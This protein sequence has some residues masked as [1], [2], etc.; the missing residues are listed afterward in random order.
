MR[1]RYRALVKEL[2][3]LRDDMVARE[4]GLAQWIDG[5]DASY[6]PSAR[7]LAHYLALRQSD[8]RPLQDGL[9]SVGLCSLGN[10]ESNVLAELDK[11]LATLH[12]LLDEP[13]PGHSRAAPTSLPTAP[14]LLELHTSAL[15]GPPPH[16]AVRIMVTL[17]TEAATDPDFVQQLVES[18]MD[19]ARIN[20][21]HDDAPT[22]RKMAA[23]VRRAA[24]QVGHS[25]RILMDLAGPKLRTGAIA[26]GPAVLKL[27]PRKD[28]YG[29][30]IANAIV[31]LRP[32]GST[33][34]LDGV[35]THMGVHAKWLQHL[36]PGDHLDFTD[37]SGSTRTLCVIQIG[38][39]GAVAECSQTTYLTPH[40]R[41]KRRRRG[42]GRRTTPLADMP[43][44]EA[45][46]GLVR[47]SSLRLVREQARKNTN[48]SPS[49][50]SVT[51]TLPQ[52]FEQVRVGERIWF[53][54]GRIGGV[55]RRIAP[56]YLEVD[57]TQARDGGEKLYGD[58]GINLPD[59]QLNLPALTDKD[60]E[61]LGVVAQLADLVGLSFVQRPEDIECL[62]KHLIGLERANMGILLKIETRRG[63]ERLPELLLSAMKSASAGIMIARGDLAVECGFERLAEVQEEILWAAEAAH[64]PVIWATQVLD[65]LAKTGRP[66]RAEITDAAMGERAECVMLNKGPYIR[67]AMFTLNDILIRMQPHQTKR[68][69]RLRA[70][71]AWMTTP[72]PSRSM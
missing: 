17:P 69:P 66:T 64:M 1:I 15:L 25:V 55:I 18:G 2:S 48:G 12:R 34:P 38:S 24:I 3:T 35:S 54:D 9:D 70:L 52:V 21:A 19:I 51:C 46:I 57:I 62:H 30:V 22:W 63:F 61:D 50:A 26:A 72:A 36:R 16:R 4:A 49:V 71:H 11:V 33:T 28:A 29:I 42:P 44:I 45:V 31:G 41:V 20:C 56:Q 14:S 6:R 10:A 27:R 39:G 7:N 65:T 67:D 47:G 68:Q 13:K 8:R 32:A 53:D 43:H 5:T 60:I 59:S 37:A 23:N 40:T 58:K